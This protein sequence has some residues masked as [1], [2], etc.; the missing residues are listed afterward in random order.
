MLSDY[1]PLVALVALALV[2]LLLFR[3]L[4]SVYGAS[5]PRAPS[6]SRKQPQLPLA[7]HRLLL[8][9]AACQGG[10]LL[11]LLWALA[12]TALQEMETSPWQGGWALFAVLVVGWLYAWRRGALT[13]R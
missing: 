13:W 9:C 10:L 2:C 5:R 6:S 12:F 4:S 7:A 3:G 1:L 8:F 11:L